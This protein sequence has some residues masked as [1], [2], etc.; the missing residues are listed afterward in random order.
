MAGSIE[1]HTRNKGYVNLF[2][3]IKDF[4][5]RF[6]DMKSSFLKI[7]TRCVATKFHRLITSHL[8]Q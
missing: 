4:S 8:R 2:V 7:G 1:G 6:H 5:Y 3:V